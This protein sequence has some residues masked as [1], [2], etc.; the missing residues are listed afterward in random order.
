MSKSNYD[1]LLAEIEAIPEAE[2][3]QPNMPID[4]FLQEAAD[5]EVWCKEDIPK[6]TAVGIPKAVFDSLPVRTGALRYA[7]SVWSKDRYSQEEARQEWDQKSPIAIGL[8]DELEHAYR[9][10]FRKRPDLLSKVQA[11]EEGTGNADLV[12]DLSDLA[13]LGKANLPL[14][15]VVGI[16]AAKLAEAETMSTEM[17]GLLAAMNGERAESGE[18][19]IIRDKAYTLLKNAVDEIREAGKFVFWK[20]S[21]KLKGYKSAYFRNR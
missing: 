7:Q 1:A 6:L 14:V 10:A 5:L 9:F 11:I 15:K 19:K 17:S 16:N 20:D 8:K 12:Q 21:N 18:G 2:V 4:A 3:K 13:V